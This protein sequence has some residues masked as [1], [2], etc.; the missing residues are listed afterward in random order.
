MAHT[1]TILHMN[2][3]HHTKNQTIIKENNEQKSVKTG[4]QGAGPWIT[5]PKTMTVLLG[6]DMKES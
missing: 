6:Q 2:I 1:E 4:Y 5:K 3:H